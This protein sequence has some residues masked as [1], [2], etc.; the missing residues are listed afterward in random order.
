MLTVSMTPCSQHAA[1]AASDA[2]SG[3]PQAHPAS[4][5]APTL[6]HWSHPLHL[7]SLED[8]LSFTV[9]FDA[10]PELRWRLPYRD[11]AV[12]VEAAGDEAGDEAAA[13]EQ[14][15]QMRKGKAQLRVVADRGLQVGCAAGCR[16]GVH[17][18]GA[19][20]SLGSSC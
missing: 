5:S 8:G 14:L 20:G 17:W 18:P 2:A 10:V 6:S 4:T 9:R 15:R 13:E 12:S 3:L 1:P 16:R 11:L 19:G 7:R